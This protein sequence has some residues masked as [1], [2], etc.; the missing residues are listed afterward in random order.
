MP[1]MYPPADPAKYFLQG[2]SQA[3]EAAT[4]NARIAEAQQA[5]QQRASMQAMQM[6][7]EQ[8]RQQEQFNVRQQQMEIQRS[9]HDAQ[10]GL[11]ESKL[12]EAKKMNN[13]KI[14]RAAR[15]Y[16]ARQAYSQ[17]VKD[18]ADPLNAALTN[19]ADLEIPGGGMATL[20]N[21]ASRKARPPANIEE[22]TVGGKK[23]ARITEPSGATRL[24]W[25]PQDRTAST[26]GNDVNLRWEANNIEKQN[27][28]LRKDLSLYDPEMTKSKSRRAHYEEEQRQLDENMKRLKEIKGQ[29]V[30]PPGQG[31]SGER[32]KV[33]SPN[34]K[35]GHIPKDQ[36]ESAL[37]E[38]YTEMDA[39]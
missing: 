26:R 18:G 34:G 12:N 4:S 6:E 14:A 38:G 10:V 25:V 9:Y 31:G 21:A 30:P 27:S 19:A 32:V 3:R 39:D 15:Q 28:A 13:E 11:A 29:L 16:K 36:L 33:K 37:K 5:L 22:V 17:A 7:I 35:V 1:A 24:Q 20:A 23:A 2:Y 8:R